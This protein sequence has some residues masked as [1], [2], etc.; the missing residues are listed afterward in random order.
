MQVSKWVD[1]VQQRCS[2]NLMVQPGTE[3][4]FSHKPGLTSLQVCAVSGVRLGFRVPGCWSPFS[5]DWA[6]QAV[7]SLCVGQDRNEAWMAEAAV[8]QQ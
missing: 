1:T 2:R 4:E 6:I 5:P 3:I 7:N 8:P